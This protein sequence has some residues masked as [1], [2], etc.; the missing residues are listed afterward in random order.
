[1]P[2]HIA[3]AGW[4]CP[5]PPGDPALGVGTHLER[6]A[7]LLPAVEINTSFYRN[8]RPSTYERWARSVPADFRFAVKVW[9]EI[10]HH[11]RLGVTDREL[12]EFLEGPVAL[13][14]KLGPLLVQLPPSFV[15]D[16]EHVGR[17]FRQLRRL[18]TG[19]VACEP[20]HPSW[21]TPE[22]ERLLADAQVA[23]VGADPA[24]VPE[25]ALPGGWNGLRYLRLHGS[26][27]M[28]ASPYSEDQLA[29]LAGLL[30]GEAEAAEAWCVFDNTQF[31][32]AWENARELWQR[33]APAGL[34][35]A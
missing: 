5:A 14:K 8:H 30:P 6:Y 28:Y 17:F 15:L 25:A 16:A 24:V 10:T 20:R 19:L 7:R 31:G 33:V 27:V 12:A 22:G 23:R 4:T 3:T 35:P 1:M 34:S 26:P 13:G 29:S 2:L 21:F 9:R 32:A 11:R 18:H